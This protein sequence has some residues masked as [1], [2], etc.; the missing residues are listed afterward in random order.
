MPMG[1]Q[2]ESSLHASS[3]RIGEVTAPI[4]GS[5][6]EDEEA[7]EEA[8]V[9]LV[10]IEAEVEPDARSDGATP[11]FAGTAPLRGGHAHTP[12]AIVTAI[13]TLVRGRRGALTGR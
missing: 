10:D 7:I 5:I 12:I 4:A 3:D 6:E 8:A 11:T 2:S 1:A 9:A 13:T